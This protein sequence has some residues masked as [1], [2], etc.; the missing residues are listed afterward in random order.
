VLPLNVVGT[1]NMVEAAIAA[2]VDRFVFASSVQA[3]EGHPV[4]HQVR[5][6]DA[7]WPANDYGVG[8]AFGEALCASAAARSATTFVSVRIGNYLDT[9]PGPEDSLRDRMAWLSPSDAV[10]LLTR[11]LTV[12]LAGHT[13]LHGVSDNAVKRLSIEVTRRAVGYAP[14]DDAFRAT[15]PG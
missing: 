11:S 4:D 10:Q 1:Y 8:K 13:V 9:A 15:A 14:T 2:G 3:V 6:H 7:P 12:G 5:E